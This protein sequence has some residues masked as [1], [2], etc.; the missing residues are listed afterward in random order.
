MAVFQNVLC[1]PS[2]R[3]RPRQG[4][5]SALPE[6]TAGFTRSLLPIEYAVIVLL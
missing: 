3:P 6:P 1:L 5:N 4:A 2:F